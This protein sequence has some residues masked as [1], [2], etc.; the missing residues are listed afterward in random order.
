MSATS[1]TLAGRRAAEKLMVDSCSIAHGVGVAGFELGEYTTIPGAEV[2]AGKCKVQIQG[3]RPPKT[4]TDADALLSL[5]VVEIHVPMSVVG[6]EVHDLVTIT[7]S[8]LDPDLVGRVYRVM[9][10]AG[11]TFATARRMR[12][13]EYR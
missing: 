3:T 12:C 13:E 1:A 7:G 6:V 10:H 9:D 5:V 11:K 8:L 4:S 2:Y